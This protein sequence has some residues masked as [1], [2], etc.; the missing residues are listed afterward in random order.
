[1]GFI[2]KQRM[3]KPCGSQREQQSAVLIN[4]ILR[5]SSSHGFPAESA[6]RRQVTSAVGL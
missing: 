2:M 4:N 1:M 6:S 3:Q 5:V